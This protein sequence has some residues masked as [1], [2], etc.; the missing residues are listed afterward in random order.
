M[1][2]M[3]LLLNRNSS[4]MVCATDDFLAM[5]MYVMC[6]NQKLLYFRVHNLIAPK[7]TTQQ[8]KNT[9]P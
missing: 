2:R 9:A 3:M 5:K 8:E 7:Y 1:M 4:T 6:S